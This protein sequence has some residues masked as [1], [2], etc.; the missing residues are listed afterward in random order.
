MAFVKKLPFVKAHFSFHPRLKKEEND[1]IISSILPR[2]D[3]LNEKGSQVNDLLKIKCSNCV[4]HYLDH[5]QTITTKH[6]NKSGLHLNY[7]GTVVLSNNLL[8]TINF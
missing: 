3:K 4:L 7:R 6:L 1:V 8:N 5:T 2:I